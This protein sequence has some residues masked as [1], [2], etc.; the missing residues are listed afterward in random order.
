MRFDA[1][2]CGLLG[3]GPQTRCRAPRHLQGG[4]PDVACGHNERS[5]S[6]SAGD[7]DQLTARATQRTRPLSD[8]EAALA[9]EL[10][11]ILKRVLG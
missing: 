10:P 2:L 1:A 11:A 3:S 5:R 9:E 6:P 7:R 8:E 4:C